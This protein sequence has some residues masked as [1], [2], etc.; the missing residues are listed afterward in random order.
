MFLG[1]VFCTFQW[2]NKTLIEHNLDNDLV[3]LMFCSTLLC[4]EKGSKNDLKRP[5]LQLSNKIKTI[6][7]LTIVEHP[8]VPQIDIKY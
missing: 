1:S 4:T 3:R 8:N 2:L 5:I 6:V 7:E